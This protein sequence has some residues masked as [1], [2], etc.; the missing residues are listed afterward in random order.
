MVLSEEKQKPLA[1]ESECVITGLATTAKRRLHFYSDCAYFA[2]CEHM[3]SAFFAD[4]ALRREYDISFSYR[5]SPEYE[6]GFHSHASNLPA[7][8]FPLRLLDFNSQVKRIPWRPVRILVLALGYALM[9]KQ[10]YVLRN[11]VMLYRLWRRR[12]IDLLHINNGGYPGA[13][14]CASAVF[15]GRMAG[16]RRIV[17][18]VNNLA[19]PYSSVLRWPD[20]LFDRLV[21][22]FVTRFIT[23]SAFAAGELR[24]VLGVPC[25]KVLNIPNGVSESERSAAPEAAHH[26]LTAARSLLVL[27]TAVLEKR[28]GH[29]YLLRALE[30][31]RGR[32]MSPLP[33]V[34]LVGDGKE[35]PALQRY[36][37]TEGLVDAVRFVGNKARPDYLTLLKSSDVV[38]LPSIS[39]EDFPN[40]VI[41]AM[42]LGKPVIASRV[43]GIPEQVDDGR[44][45]FIVA[46]RDVAG[47]ADALQCLLEDRDLRRSMGSAGREK[48]CKEYRTPMAVGRYR[49]L[50]RE[51]LHDRADEYPTGSAHW[52]AETE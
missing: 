30:L 12:E 31:M 22:R 36:V 35:A 42:S 38:A 9:V 13:V 52:Q 15:A 32:G 40:V 41:E 47:L 8:I 45:G 48:F 33:L 51:V 39:H 50:F 19:V 21:V 29:V 28:K 18:V 46:P 44:T 24:R 16:I 34:V 43:A 3:L 11:T 10:W 7:E 26:G 14:S 17:Y 1:A 27:V 4:D 2:G 23:G 37:E 5:Y 20:Y 6:A 49:A 25:N